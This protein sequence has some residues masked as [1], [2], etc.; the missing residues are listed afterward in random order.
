MTNGYLPLRPPLHQ[1]IV[2]ADLI[3]N[4][5][6]DEFDDRIESIDTVIP[7]G[8]RWQDDGTSTKRGRVNFEPF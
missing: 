6:D 3:Y 8:H 2:D 5:G 1:K 7:A 4:S